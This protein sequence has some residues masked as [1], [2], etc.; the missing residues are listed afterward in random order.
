MAENFPLKISGYQK[1]AVKKIYNNVYKTRAVTAADVI[2]E[3]YISEMK[4]MK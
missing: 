2:S 4:P 1:R 3:K